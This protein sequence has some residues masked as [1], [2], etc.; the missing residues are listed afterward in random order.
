MQALPG[1]AFDGDRLLGLSREMYS[2]IDP[3]ALMVSPWGW[4]AGSVLGWFVQSSLSVQRACCHPVYTPRTPT[5]DD[6]YFLV[7]HISMAA[8][9]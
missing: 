6:T 4:G 3:P 1:L 2:E 7:L 5:H 8:G 9:A